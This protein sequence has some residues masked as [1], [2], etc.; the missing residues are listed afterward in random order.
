M[1]HGNSGKRR[2]AAAAIDIV[3]LLSL[4][5]AETMT[6]VASL[7]LLST[8]ER[9][10]QIAYNKYEIQTDGA[11][12]AIQLLDNEDHNVTN[13]VTLPAG[14]VCPPG[15]R[16]YHTILTAQASTY[17]RWQTLIFYHHFR[18][19]QRMNPCTE[20]TGFTRLLSSP[21]G[22]ADWPERRR[23]QHTGLPSST[24]RPHE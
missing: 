8:I 16:P 21:G 9:V 11:G 17:Q 7:L 2:R 20:M 1:Y 23:P 12:G 10:S 6:I 24:R 19:A 4:A 22:G 14:C 5:F 15:R 18:K 3:V 13:W